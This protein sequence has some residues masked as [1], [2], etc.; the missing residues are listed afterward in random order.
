MP[1]FEIMNKATFNLLDKYTS[2]PYS[3]RSELDKKMSRLALL[4]TIIYNQ[5]EDAD[6]WVN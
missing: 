4:L 3:W 1:K 5:K 2:I 6:L